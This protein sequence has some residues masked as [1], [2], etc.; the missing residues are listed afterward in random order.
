MRF[1]VFALFTVV[2]AFFAGGDNAA[3]LSVEEE[4][5]R[6]AGLGTDEASLLDFFRKRAM[7]KTADDKLLA[8]AR[9]LADPNAEV[10]NHT[11]AQLVASGP[12]AIPALRYVLNDLDDPVAAKLAERCLEW[13]EGNRRTSIPIAAA[14]L[15]AARKPPGAVEALLAYLP[16]A[17]DR[18]VVESVKAAL[19]TL[20][21][22]GGKPAPALVEA[23]HDPVSMRRAIAVE[24][25]CSG[26]LPQVLPDVRKLLADPKPQVR[27]QAALALAER[28]D[29]EAIGVLIDL[30][31]DL[32]PGQRKVVENALQQLAGEWSPNPTLAGDDPVSRKIRRDAWAAWSR[33]TDGPALL[34]AFREQT[35]DADQLIGALLLI[36]KL[37]DNGFAVR[38]RAASQ[39]IALGT[40]VLPLLREATRSDDLER[41]RRAALCLKQIAQN[42]DE[43]KLP[44]A[45]A[46]LLAVRKPAGA[47]EALLAYLPFTEDAA[48]SDEISRALKRLVRATG[49]ADPILVKTLGDAMPVRRLAAAETLVV[50]GGVE[51]LQAVRK[52]LNDKVPQVRLRV[53]VALALAHDKE[54]VPALIDIVAQLPVGQAW[55]AEDVLHRLAG[56]D[57]PQVAPGDDPAAQKQ[58]LGAWTA[59]WQKNVAKVD[60]A[61]LDAGAD[62]AGLMLVV[63]IA[64]AVKAGGA[65][66]ALPGGPAGAAGKKGGKGGGAA[67]PPPGGKKGGGG[68]AAKVM[69]GTDRVIAL[70]RSATPRWEIDNLA[71]PVDACLLPGNRLLVAEA[72]ADLVT[73]RDFKGN[74]LWHANLPGTPVSVQRL[75]NGNTF[76]GLASGVLMEVDRAGKT[77]VNVNM[78][79]NP[80]G[81]AAGGAPVVGAGGFMFNPGNL[82]LIGAYKTANGQMV[83]LTDQGTCTYLSA[84]GKEIKS[85]R[86]VQPAR[87]RMDV[88][89]TGHLLTVENDGMIREYDAE[90]K[91]VWQVNAPP[92]MGSASRLPSG[93]TL[94]AT[95]GGG[96]VVELDQG[97]RTV[98]EYRSPLGY[99]PL[100]VRQR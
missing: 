71:S 91:V 16:F 3:R 23:L 64:Y 69:V 81:G 1:T 39:L 57:A 73:E 72:G 59:W 7:Q 9:K 26:D 97:G 47:T 29:E 11:A 58:F 19:V 83:C 5:L 12:S 4:T 30:L 68:V 89:A 6:S 51:N 38:E 65:A 14:R 77:V 28:Q 37:G 82:S 13:L 50:A 87:G 34:A 74:V 67:N 54:A 18:S 99:R 44:M 35:L 96:G 78:G 100:R 84:A 41:A 24:V 31:L 62:S 56:A 40:K 63:E 20:V 85:F 32:P 95:Y 48:M 33:N 79:L 52:L 8:L 49:Q 93:H 22:E 61:K 43:H 46:R 90:G 86:Q 88:T 55:E 92:G 45:A 70:D 36:Q 27:L 15:L 66:G 98:W 80:A 60:F 75:A 94:V 2:V 17:D 21:A 53:A 10:R 42:E 76:I 25:L